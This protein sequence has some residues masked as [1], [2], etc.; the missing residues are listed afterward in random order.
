MNSVVT[1]GVEHSDEVWF[2][3]QCDSGDADGALRGGGLRRGPVTPFDRHGHPAGSC[4]KSII[5]VNFGPLK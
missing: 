2:E 5:H 4:N 1:A 3:G